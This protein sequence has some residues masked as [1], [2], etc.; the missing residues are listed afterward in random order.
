MPACHSLF[1]DVA[2][3]GLPEVAKG[4]KSKVAELGYID[5]KTAENSKDSLEAIIELEKQFEPHVRNVKN[6]LAEVVQDSVNIREKIDSFN[7]RVDVAL[8]NAMRFNALIRKQHDFP[9]NMLPDDVL[10]NTG[11]VVANLQLARKLGRNLLQHDAEEL[12]KVAQLQELQYSAMFEP[13]LLYVVSCLQALNATNALSV[14]P[15]QH[16]FLH[17]QPRCRRRTDVQSSSFL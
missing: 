2:T 6:T 15:V 14:A 16:C 13:G 1:F 9:N 12:V 5:D 3:Q 10:S 8:K 11:A 7:E 4:L 17:P